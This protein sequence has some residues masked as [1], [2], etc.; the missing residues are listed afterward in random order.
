MVANVIVAAIMFKGWP[1][2]VGNAKNVE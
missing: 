2:W 1:K